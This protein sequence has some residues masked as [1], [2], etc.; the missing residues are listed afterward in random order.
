MLTALS[1]EEM[2]TSCHL[3][4]APGKRRVRLPERKVRGNNRGAFTSYGT[5]LP[6][7]ISGAHAPPY[8]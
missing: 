4:P 8:P 5:T 3:R 6:P 7:P 2:S 1:D